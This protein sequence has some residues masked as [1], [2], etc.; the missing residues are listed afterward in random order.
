MEV[1]E[2]FLDENDY[3]K[4]WQL[5]PVN[6]RPEL[7]DNPFPLPEMQQLGALFDKYRKPMY[8][9]ID[10][11][12]VK[13]PQGATTQEM[14]DE[15]RQRLLMRFLRLLLDAMYDGRTWAQCC[16]AIKNYIDG[17]Q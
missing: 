14:I 13:Q 2:Y 16:A 3:I 10:N 12:I 5:W 4:G 17:E 11:A 6:K 7:K 15:K 9:L 8:K 1:I